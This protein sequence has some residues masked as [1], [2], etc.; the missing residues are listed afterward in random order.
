MARTSSTTSPAGPLEEP[1][2]STS[3]P[4]SLMTSL[5]PWLANSRACSRPMPRPAPV[6]TTTR[7]SQIP[8]FSC[9]FG[10]VQLDCRALLGEPGCSVRLRCRPVLLPQLS[11]EDLP[12]ILPRQLRHE[13]DAAGALEVG[14]VVPTEGH[15]LRR[16]F[17]R[18]LDPFGQLH[19]GLH[20]LAPVVVGYPDGGHVV[21]RRMLQEHS[22]HLGRVDVHA[23]RN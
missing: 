12:S 13:V 2:P 14:Q 6:M 16:Q 21:H 23:A 10:C 22:V 20:G 8:T 15:E 7:P 9:S 17:V 5:A 18:S 11:L 3:A 1:E 19:H 4:R